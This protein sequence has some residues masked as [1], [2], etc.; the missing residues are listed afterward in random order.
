MPHAPILASGVGHGVH[1]SRAAQTIRAMAA[2]ARHA[3]AAQPDTVVVLAPHAAR[4]PGTFGLWAVDL[5]RGSLA[6]FGAADTRVELPVDRALASRLERE[7][8]ARGLKTCRITA[9]ELEH[10]AI[11][12]LSYLAAA[13]WRSPT[14]V[15]ELS[16]RA[17]LDA[18]GLGQ[19]IAAAATALQR[20]LALIACGDMSRRAPA[21]PP[22]GEQPGGAR[23]DE[24][25]LRLLREGA[26][27]EIPRLATAIAHE[28]AQEV[29]EVTRV[30]LAAAGPATTGGAV[31][32]YE[33]PFGVGYGVAI[34]AAGGGAE[35]GVYSHLADL[36][37]IAR[38]TVAALLNGGPAAAPWVAA[39]ALAEPRAVFVALRDA[40]ET[41]RAQ[42]CA[43]QPLRENL[44]QET[45]HG[46]RAAAAGDGHFPP[47]KPSELERVRF[48]VSVLGPLEPV[49]GPEALDPARFGLCVHAGHGRMALLLPATRG[50]ETAAE[51]VRIARHKA[52]IA[53]RESATLQ[54]FTAVTYQG[55][56][57]PSDD[58]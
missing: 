4:R 36:P 14:V 55:P 25:F 18:E 26:G 28:A 54:R 49:A 44:A 50:V 2:L 40:R 53:P 5:V 39:G 45:W 27:G 48:T 20:R 37:A 29:L 52:G 30:A 33:H 42:W 58:E 51:Q 47:L 16:P 24:T 19:A 43:P 11:V 23:F 10:G 56:P 12:P 3:L 32:S 6:Q 34:L 31:L 17:E 22:G 41:L 38:E 7:A 15:I 8:A 35:A 13:G 21:S 46:A 57:L 1:H 9:G